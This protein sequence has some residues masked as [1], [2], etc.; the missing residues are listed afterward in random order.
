MRQINEEGLDII[1]RWEQGPEGSFAPVPYRDP[2][3][4]ATVGWGHMLRPHDAFD[5]P[6]SA[7]DADEL[8]AADLER[9][10]RYVEDLVEVEIN[11]NQFS[12]LVSF[13]FNVGPGA[14]QRS[15]LLRKLN[16]GD[17]EGA[18]N[19]FPRWRKAGGRILRGLELRRAD[20]RALFEQEV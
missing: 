19:E 2:A 15:T 6:L 20:E 13:C 18:A 10:E 9:F 4:H 5:Y 3:G 17:F 1:K 7:E 16:E 8:L 12:A 14:L 11:D